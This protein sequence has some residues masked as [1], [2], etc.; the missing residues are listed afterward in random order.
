MEDRMSEEKFMRA[1]QFMHEM[2]GVSRTLGRNHNARIVFRGNKAAARHNEI[3]YPAMPGDQWLSQ[4]TVQV[5]RGFA[6]HEGLGHM[7]HTDFDVLL[8]AMKEAADAGDIMLKR[9][10]NGIE[11][12][13]IEKIVTNDF[14]GTKKNLEVTS[15]VVNNKYLENYAEDNT[16]ADDFRRVA[17]IAV[18]WEGR[19]RPS[20][21]TDTIDQ[22][23]DTLPGQS[24]EGRE[25]VR[26]HRYSLP[27]QVGRR[28]GQ[29]QWPPRYAGRGRSRQAPLQGG[30][31][32]ARGR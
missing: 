17:P 5:F 1:D 25:M 7:A 21:G 29:R 22:C 27:P 19:R 24:C 4:R 26:P 8:P 15:E 3:I 6:D 13:R 20:Y 12:V 31:G 10:I 32:R 28:Q 2:G 11:D 16:L 14:A 18:T 23:L 30:T 9:L